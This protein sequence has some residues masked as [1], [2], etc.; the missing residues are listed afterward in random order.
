MLPQN[1]ILPPLARHGEL[2]RGFSDHFTD[3]KTEG[4]G[5]E[6]MPG[7]AS[8]PGVL[9][10]WPVPGHHRAVLAAPRW[11]LRPRGEGGRRQAEVGPSPPGGLPS[12]WT[13]PLQALI[14]FCLFCLSMRHVGS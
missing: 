4:Q 8:N 14:F 5:E 3:G 9:S 12:T 13:P 7:Q 6:R 10:P 1:C 2:R 11:G